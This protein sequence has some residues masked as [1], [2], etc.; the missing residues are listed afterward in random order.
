MSSLCFR[1][2]LFVVYGY[3]VTSA[4]NDDDYVDYCKRARTVTYLVLCSLFQIE[5]LL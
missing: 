3:L 4:Q 1:I 2:F 5:P